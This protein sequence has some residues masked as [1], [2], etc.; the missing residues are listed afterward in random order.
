MSKCIFCDM[1]AEN[2]SGPHHVLPES[3]RKQMGW[4]NRKFRGLQEFRVPICEK[5]HR[6]LHLLMEPLVVIIKWLRKNPPLPMDFVFL[7]T[8]VTDKLSEEI[9]PTSE[10]TST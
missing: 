4:S 8:D 1:D 5:C 6:K 9:E 10:D 7:L 2:N 3:V